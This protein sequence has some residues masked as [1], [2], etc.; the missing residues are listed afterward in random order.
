M[1]WSLQ[2]LVKGWSP[3]KMLPLTLGIDEEKPEGKY[4][5]LHREEVT[6]CLTD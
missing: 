1:H 2:N 5:S 6:L 3:E 4:F